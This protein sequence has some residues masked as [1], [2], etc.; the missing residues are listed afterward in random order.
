M[1]GYMD[2]N[3]LQD[4]GLRLMKPDILVKG[5]VNCVKLS[6]SVNPFKECLAVSATLT[7][8][9]RFVMINIK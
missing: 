7:F 1:K 9:Y 3:F 6:A 4:V 2:C 8:T 5:H